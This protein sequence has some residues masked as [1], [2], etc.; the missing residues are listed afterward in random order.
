ME[1]NDQKDLMAELE[2]SLL[3]YKGVL[4][5]DVRVQL[6]D[7]LHCIAHDNLGRRND[8]KRLVGIALEL[9]DNAQRYNVS[10]DV[11][12]RWHVESY[13]LVVTIRNRANRTDAERLM[14]AVHAIQRMNPEEIA[15]AFKRQL[16]DDGFGEKGGAGLGM[17]HIAKKIG[18]NITANVEHL[19]INEYLCTSQVVASLTPRAK[20][21]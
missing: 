2:K 14:E 13:N 3:D 17:L 7:L 9:L 21:A 5:S 4:S 1:N 16:T 10:K 12:F 15:L 11:E 20:R 8:L 19:N 18:N 6:L